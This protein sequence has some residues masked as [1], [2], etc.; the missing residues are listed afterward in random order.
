[1]QHLPLIRGLVLGYFSLLAIEVKRVGPVQTTPTH[2]HALLCALL[3]SNRQVRLG[4]FISLVGS[5]GLTLHP[6]R[7]CELEVLLGS[8]FHTMQQGGLKVRR[9]RGYVC[10]REDEVQEGGSW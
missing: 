8:N 10:G 1:M 9:R 4:Y 7:H 6:L 5:F 2:T 3:L